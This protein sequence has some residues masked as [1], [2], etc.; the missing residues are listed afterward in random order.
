MA[1]QRN[2]PFVVGL[3]AALCIAVAVANANAQPAAGP[4]K[5][6]SQT[7]PKN[8]LPRENGDSPAAPG[9]AHD[10]RGAKKDVNGEHSDH[11]LAEK[12]KGPPT[13]GAGPP[14]IR[15]KDLGPVDT[16]ITVRP[17]PHRTDERKQNPPLHSPTGLRTQPPHTQRPGDATTRNSIGETVP[18]SAQP[19]ARSP[20]VAPA[21]MAHG[22]GSPGNTAAASGNPALPPF[23]AHPITTAPEAPRSTINGTSI[24]RRGNSPAGVGGRAKPPAGING[25]AIRPKY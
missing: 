6:D 20:S 24:A 11:A 1:T 18:S 14:E 19:A 8:A 13:K 9:P 23:H 25:S 21:A 22:G 15:M 12:G 4:A 10:N 17:P 16:Q 2:H 7:A 5:P 3:F